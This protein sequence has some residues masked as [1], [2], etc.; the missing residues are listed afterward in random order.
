MKFVLCMLMLIGTVGHAQQYDSHREFSFSTGTEGFY[1]GSTENISC[2]DTNGTL[3][4]QHKRESGS[5]NIWQDIGMHGMSDFEISVDVKWVIGATNKPFGLLFGTQNAS[6]SYGFSLAKDQHFQVWGYR[7]G[8]RFVII[9]WKKL[10]DVIN[11]DGWN[12]LNVV[13]RNREWIF[14]INNQ[15][16]A[17]CTAWRLPGRN[18]GFSVSGATTIQFDNLHV[19]QNDRPDIN[20]VANAPENVERVNLGPAINSIY[21]EVNPVI[22]ADEQTIYVNRKNHPE[23]TPNPKKSNDEAHVNDEIWVSTRDEN[24]AWKPVQRMAPPINN[25]NNNS[26]ISVA[27]DGNTLILNNHYSNDGSYNVGPGLSL[28][29]RTPEGTWSIPQK[30]LIKDYEN[31]HPKNYATACMAPDRQVLVISVQRKD[32]LNSGDLYVCFRESDTSFSAPV[33]LGETINTIGDDFAPFVAADG[34]TLYFSSYGHPGY[35]SADVFVAKRLDD[36][37]TNWSEPK[38]LGPGI[39]KNTFDAYYTIPASGEV[40]YFVSGSDDENNSNDVFKLLLSEESRPEAVA[41]VKGTVFDSKTNKPLG[42]RIAYT[43]L[44]S[45][46]QL[47]IA[48]SDPVTGAYTIVLPFGVQYGFSAS[49]EEYYPTS[50]RLDLR[51]VASYKEIR[52]DLYLTPIEAGARVVLENVFFDTDKAT[53]RAESINEL[54][55][56]VD[57]LKANASVSVEIS[58]HTDSR[59][60]QA[61]N[62]DL[63]DRRA[64]SVVKWLSENGVNSTR[65]TARGYGES[66]PR[67]TNDTEDGRQLNRRVEFVIQ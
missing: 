61:H 67:A 53:L 64:Q 39:N 2:L 9:D 18:V 36:T 43:D 49:R 5:W 44:S 42:A 12:T 22:S 11:A 47:G 7:D 60:D 65:L 1:D 23:N 21:T 51:S 46:K 56:L 52:R 54:Q 45:N 55:R 63:S 13:Q 62:Q 59:G 3:Q 15:Q 16:V 34:V 31:H 29:K 35:G 25:Y 14:N 57:F 8:K 50:E 26:V 37:W 32:A 10:P 4:F 19:W 48:E 66:Q 33:S 30:I 17:T 20:V 41:L 24:G 27:P 38:N 40:A 28:S 58:G 6:N